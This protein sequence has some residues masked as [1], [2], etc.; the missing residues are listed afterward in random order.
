MALPHA[1]GRNRSP[2]E[3]QW[4]V[5]AIEALRGRPWT[6]RRGNRRVLDVPDVLVVAP[7][8]AQVAALTAGLPK[9]ARVGTVD[10][11]QGQEAPVVIYSMASSSAEDAPRG[12]AFLFNPNR[13]NVAT[14]R[15]QC[16]SILV[17]S[18]RLLEP[19]CRTPEQ[20]RWA[21]GLCRFR[22]LAKEVRV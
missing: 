13:L 18:P 1:G 5:A 3:A 20:M 6:D 4:V 19:S 11:F 7:Y 12:M 10:K 22:E 14:S 9:G 21:N 8:N 15:A 17:A 16:A 2:E